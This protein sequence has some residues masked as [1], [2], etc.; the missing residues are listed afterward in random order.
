[1]RP[2]LAAMV[3]GMTAAPSDKGGNWRIT[4]RIGKIIT[5]LLVLSLLVGLATIANA[6]PPVQDNGSPP[7]KGSAGQGGIVE[8]QLVLDRSKASVTQLALDEDQKSIVPSAPVSNPVP[9]QKGSFAPGPVMLAEYD[10]E[11][12][13]TT[14]NSAGIANDVIIGV[15]A[16]AESTGQTAAASSSTQIMFENFEGTFPPADPLWTRLD[17][18]GTTN[19]EYLWDDVNCF[20]IESGGGWSAWPAAGGANGFNPCGGATYP[21]NAN[22]WLIY[23][24]FSLADAQSA[25]LDFY[26]RSVIEDCDPITD[27]DFLFWG[28]STNGVN[29]F[30]NF[31]A[32]DHT[33]GPFNIDN[34]YNFVSFDLSDLSGESMVWIAIVFIS[35]GSVSFEGPFID[36]IS[37]RKS[38]A[39]RRLLT[40]ENFDVVVFPNEAWL[41]FDNDGNFNG[42][43][44]WDDVY[45]ANNTNQC[46]S[47]SGDWS[48]WP[49][50]EGANALDACA[51]DEYPNNAKSWLMHG[52]FSLQAA[53][54]AYVD[55]YYRNQSELG[56]D[57]LNWM[58]STDGT[59]FDGY[60]I[61]GTHTSGPHPGDF[62]L[63]RFDLSNVPIQGDLRGE[64]A[65]WL[66]F[67]F[68]SDGSV[69]GQGPFIDDVSI[70][71]E[72]NQV[73]LPYTANP[74]PPPPGGALTFQ[75][76]TG[77]PLILELIGIG[78]RQ[79]SAVV[80]PQTWSD[81]P[82]A[83]YDWIAS[84]TCPQ[85]QGQVGSV[86]PPPNN[87]APVTIIANQTVPI[88]A[89]N[90]GVFDCGG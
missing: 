52:P 32:G 77:N 62:N 84:G 25:S 82:P 45:S 73:F 75:N 17:V 28:S 56:F 50:A 8:G 60:G 87:R 1:M 48:M 74:E 54:E 53:S 49:A 35:D 37:L 2:A 55:F 57:Y 33:G 18:D 10:G 27:C 44:K 70:V 64:P 80:G 68:E 31:E 46:R 63:L 40:D 15:P 47:R 43:F 12:L 71:A 72:I 20:P 14:P 19:G 21:N 6:G 16:Q 66:A 59:F 86:V 69:T 26:F 9:S 88:N 39:S 11:T 4:M 7:G 5:G 76:Q 83:T 90:G 22:S 3:A 36:F 42:E 89:E 38:T 23:G 67:I 78:T 79:F 65:V 13:K 30:G 41:A 29:F 85:G 51:G 58:A 81:L 24:P 34:G 61:S